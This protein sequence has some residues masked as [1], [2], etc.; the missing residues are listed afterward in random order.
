MFK[1]KLKPHFL[2][3]QMNQN[4]SD[5]YYVGN[6]VLCKVLFAIKLGFLSRIFIDILLF[7]NES[8]VRMHWCLSCITVAC[9]LEW[10]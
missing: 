4:M 6:E 1:S 3:R 7:V 8:C 9:I 2:H 5:M 10:K